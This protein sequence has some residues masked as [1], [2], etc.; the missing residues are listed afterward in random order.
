MR[1]IIMTILYYPAFKKVAVLY[2]LRTIFTN[3]D[4]F[5]MRSLYGAI[6]CVIG[7]HM[8]HVK[9]FARNC[10]KPNC[11]GLYICFISLHNFSFPVNL[12]KTS[13]EETWTFE[14]YI[15]MPPIAKIVNDWTSQACAPYGLVWDLLTSLRNKRLK[16]KIWVSFFIWNVPVLKM[17]EKQD[18]IKMTEWDQ[19][20]H[21]MGLINSCE[22]KN[23]RGMYLQ[24]DIF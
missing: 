14:L 10:I 20:T 17:K 24:N 3:A 12:K 4:V 23:S 9:V 7:V 8:S 18:L 13:D 15:L 16:L 21:N 1:V 19:S 2:I 11:I 6:V 5:K 22:K